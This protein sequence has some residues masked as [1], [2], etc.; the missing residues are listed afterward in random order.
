[1]K[2][3]G[4]VDREY[5]RW[6]SQK[7]KCDTQSQ[8]F[9]SVRLKDFYPTLVVLSVGI[10]CSATIFLLELTYHKTKYGTFWPK[11]SRAIEAEA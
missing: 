4:M 11:D 2:E 10:I 8:G 7:P 1:L 9:V 5:K 3:A 6:F